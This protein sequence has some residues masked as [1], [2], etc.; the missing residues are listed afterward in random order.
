MA[1]MRNPRPS[2]PAT[3]VTAQRAARLHR[4]VT[5]LAAGPQTR[6]A[7]RKRMRMDVRS[8]YR[9]LEL[10]RTAGIKVPLRD[11]HY[12]LNMGAATAYARLPFPDP[13]LSLGDA[14]QLARGRTPAHTKLKAIIG[15][16]VGK[17]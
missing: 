5:L 12:V 3:T 17:K 2:T 14:Q 10:L 11:R 13:H 9:D 8:F 1:K 15:R 4:L 16:I 7:I 6:E